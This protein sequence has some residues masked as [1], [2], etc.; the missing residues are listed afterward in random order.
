MN[1]SELCFERNQE[2]LQMR[3]LTILFPSLLVAV[4]AH[5]VCPDPDY[6]S[7]YAV[8][9]AGSD[10]RI[11]TSLALK[12]I[13]IEIE[14]VFDVDGQATT[15]TET[16]TFGGGGISC[17]T[18]GFTPVMMVEKAGVETIYKFR[19][20]NFDAVDVESAQT[21]VWDEEFEI[22][23]VHAEGWLWWVSC[24]EDANDDA[25]CDSYCKEE[26]YVSGSFD[27]AP[28]PAFGRFCGSMFCA[29]LRHD[30]GT[31]IRTIQ[32]PDTI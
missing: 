27:G 12:K 2:V 31:D 23:A 30:G 17:P 19:M 16:C 10:T 18:L 29:C 24:V 1:L 13:D 11:R 9:A 7:V 26:G 32:D 5:A 8:E 15:V 4:A 3:V 21:H 22:I 25:Q 6:S 20:L 14:A 28:D